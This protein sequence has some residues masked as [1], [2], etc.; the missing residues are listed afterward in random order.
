[1]TTCSN[2]TS[3]GNSDSLILLPISFRCCCRSSGVIIVHPE[4][5][6]H[7]DLDPARVERFYNGVRYLVG[8]LLKNGFR[9]QAHPVTNTLG[10]RPSRRSTQMRA[11]VGE[12]HC[13]PKAF[14]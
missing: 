12:S 1:M 2:T 7:V 4:R 9:D 8:D 10:A 3:S 11:E 6:L 13:L 14:T 5:D